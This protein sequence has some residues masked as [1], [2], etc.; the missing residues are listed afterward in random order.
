MPLPVKFLCKSLKPHEFCCVGAHFEKSALQMCSI[1]QADSP[2]PNHNTSTF[3][4]PPFSPTATPPPSSPDYH[5]APSPPND[6]STGA[7]SL[8]YHRTV[9]C[10]ILC[11]A[12]D[13]VGT[14]FALVKNLSQLYAA[15]V[16]RSVT[17]LGAL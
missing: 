2:A 9:V 15:C 10:G 17:G 4:I 12:T 16:C 1:V 11:R 6:L 8:L 3:L 14:P 5:L 13:L 7:A